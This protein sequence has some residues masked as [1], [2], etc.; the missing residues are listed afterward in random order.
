[1]KAPF[2]RVLLA[3][4]DPV[5]L[6]A[7]CRALDEAGYEVVGLT[8]DGPDA[9][10]MIEELEP[11]IVLM[12]RYLRR[13][14][15]FYVLEQLNCLPLGSMPAAAVSL[16]EDRKEEI[17]RAEKLGAFAYLPEPVLPA[18]MLEAVREARPMSRMIPCF[19]NE[20][21]VRRI[22]DRMSLDRNLKG[23]EYLVA[24]IGITCRSHSFYRAI[25]TVVYPETARMFGATKAQVEHCIRHAI[26]SAWMKGD[27]EQQYNYFGNTI[28]E[29]RAKP[30]NGEFIARITEALRLE[31][32]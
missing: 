12:S 25:T 13:R 10:R 7:G 20:A 24:A 17:E 15:A 22:L 8:D 14:D 21:S 19:A 23:Y 18:D 30:T 3:V 29:N 2:S 27:L 28:D 4:Y 11:D 5:I 1:M 16:S 26:E 6:G 32:M 9:L 31:A